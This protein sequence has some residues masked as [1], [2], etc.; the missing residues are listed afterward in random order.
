M[1]KSVVITLR[2]DPLLLASIMSYFINNGVN[3]VSRSN[4]V[5][6]ALTA[7]EQALTRQGHTSPFTTVSAAVDYLTHSFGELTTDQ[8]EM[9]KQLQIESITSEITTELSGEPEAEIVDDIQEALRRMREEEEN[10]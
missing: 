10:E 2:T 8:K 5:N 3:P 7:F 1:S 4:L 6:L 9:F